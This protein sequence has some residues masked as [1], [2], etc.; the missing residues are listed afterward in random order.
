MYFAFFFEWFSEEQTDCAGDMHQSKIGD[1][2]LTVS[3]SFRDL[4]KREL[5]KNNLTEIT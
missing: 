1:T 3:R 4:Q 5:S 2:R